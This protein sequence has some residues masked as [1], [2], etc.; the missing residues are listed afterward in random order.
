A[1]CRSLKRPPAPAAAGRRAGS[2]CW[3]KPTP[4]DRLT[5]AR[6]RRDFRHIRPNTAC[7]AQAPKPSRP[8]SGR[9]P[10]RKNTR[11]TPRHDVHTPRRTG[12]AAARKAK[13]T[14]SRP[15]RTG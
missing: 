1:L 11:P 5:P 6:V 12:T 13:S 14:T 9:S 3:E 2:A 7:P 8:G 10:G 4:S 15:R